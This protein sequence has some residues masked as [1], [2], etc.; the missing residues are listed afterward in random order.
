M[1]NKFHTCKDNYKEIGNRIYFKKLNW[2]KKIKYIQLYILGK[3]RF[4]I[5]GE[6]NYLELGNILKEMRYTFK[7]FT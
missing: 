6:Y 7:L 4:I 5:M 1:D 3:R 2:E